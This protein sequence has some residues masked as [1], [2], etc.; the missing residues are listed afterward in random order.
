MIHL[1][2]SLLL[3]TARAEYRAFELVIADNELGT[4][5]VEIST[6]DPNQYRGYYPVKYTES[7]TYRAT[8]RCKGNTSHKP[9]CSQPENQQSRPAPPAQKPAPTSLDQKSKP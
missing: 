1:L 2:L 5:R 9:V 7:V 4:E 6:L 8:W 3:Q